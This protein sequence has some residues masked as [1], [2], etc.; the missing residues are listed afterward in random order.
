MKN[1][2]NHQP[3]WANF[4]SHGAAPKPSPHAPHLFRNSLRP[5]QSAGPGLLEPEPSMG[6]ARRNMLLN[7]YDKDDNLSSYDKGGTV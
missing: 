2:P 3:G 5:H 7:I 1:V 4:F 6:T